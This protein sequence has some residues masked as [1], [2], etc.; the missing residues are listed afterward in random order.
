MA[1]STYLKILKSAGA[2]ARSAQEA[3]VDVTCQFASCALVLRTAG[4]FAKFL[5]A[6]KVYTDPC[7]PK[8][9]FHQKNAKYT[10]FFDNRTI[11]YNPTIPAMLEVFIYGG[12]SGQ[13]G[14]RD[15]CHILETIS[16]CPTYCSI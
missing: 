12:A 2:H 5:L 9:I 7:S 14:G 16:S 13:A 8:G 11:P 1:A 10:S 15:R 6:F 4:G 3:C